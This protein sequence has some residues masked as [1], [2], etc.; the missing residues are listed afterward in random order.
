MAPR[1]PIPAPTPKPYPRSVGETVGLL[2]ANHAVDANL[3]G[4]APPP[5]SDGVGRQVD[6]AAIDPAAVLVN[7]RKG[8]SVLEFRQPSRVDS[9]GGS[10]SGHAEN[11]ADEH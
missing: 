8:F 3:L 11:S 7:D 9:L 5:D 10:M 2:N 1:I 4:A 6:E